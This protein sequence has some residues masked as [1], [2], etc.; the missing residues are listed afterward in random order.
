MPDA[1]TA[2]RACL[3][4]MAHARI[5]PQDIIQHY[6]VHQAAHFALSVIFQ[7]RG[8]PRAQI[9]QRDIT[10]RHLVQAHVPFVLQ[11]TSLV[12][13]QLRVPFVRQATS[14]GQGRHRAIQLSMI[15][16]FGIVLQAQPSPTLSRSPRHLT[17]AR[18]A[19]LM[20]YT[21]MVSMI[22]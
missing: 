15:L 20:G 21:S 10:H 16:I 8:R 5:V 17:M 14:L 18:R 6:R 4:A 22:I 7:L 9:A 19:H 3:E 13:G 12:Q 11:A 2:K 1:M